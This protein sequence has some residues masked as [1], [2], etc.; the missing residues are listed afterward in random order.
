VLLRKACTACGAGQFPPT[1]AWN[2]RGRVFPDMVLLAHNVL[3]WVGGSRQVMDGTLGAAATLGGAVAMYNA[4][5]N[6]SG[7]APLGFLN[8]LLYS[9]AASSQGAAF[10]D[11]VAGSSRCRDAAQGCCAEGWQACPGFDPVSGLGAPVFSVLEA[12]F[13]VSATGG[14]TAVRIEQCGDDDKLA[15]ARR[16]ATLVALSIVAACALPAACFYTRRWY[17]KRK[18]L[19]AQAVAGEQ[20]VNHAS[21]ASYSRM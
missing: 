9:A 21:Q 19:E 1:N 6:A 13:N 11:I 5:R 2:A 7:A 8:P 3:L 12:Y 14:Y 15:R 20:S 16:L 18:R 10:H 4:R 17:R